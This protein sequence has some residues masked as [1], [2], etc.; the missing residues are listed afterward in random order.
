MPG[1]EWSSRVVEEIIGWD[2][3]VSIT[4]ICL[5]EYPF[6]ELREK[7]RGQ[8][9]HASQIPNFLQDSEIH[10]STTHHPSAR[11]FEI[12]ERGK[13]PRNVFPKT[14][15]LNENYKA[16]IELGKFQS[17]ARQRDSV[18]YKLR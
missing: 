8:I 7:N 16:V 5:L 11:I 18:H 3:D 2:K 10:L 12:I 15:Q 13:W 1:K 9:F 6:L 14:P 17:D 4:E